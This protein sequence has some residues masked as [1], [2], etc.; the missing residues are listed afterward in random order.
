LEP[1]QNTSLEMWSSIWRTAA[2]RYGSARADIDNVIA[3]FEA[4]VSRRMP[5]QPFGAFDNGNDL[6]A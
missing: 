6:L 3:A 5:E 4:F 1:A 2:P